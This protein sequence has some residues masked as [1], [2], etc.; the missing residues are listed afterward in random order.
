MPLNAESSNLDDFESPNPW[1]FWH[2]G[3]IPL[4]AKNLDLDVFESRNLQLDAGAMSLGAKSFNLNVFEFPN[5]EIEAFNIL[6]PYPWVLKDLNVFEFRNFQIE[7]LLQIE[8][9]DNLTPCSWVLKASIWMF[10]E[11]QNSNPKLSTSWGHV[12]GC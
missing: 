5:L 6:G 8:N 12:S 4:D 9:Y 1:H 3:A 10:L 7:A 11:P 2:H